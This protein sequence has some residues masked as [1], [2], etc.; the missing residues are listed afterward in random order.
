[1]STSLNPTA[2][3][4]VLV[5][6]EHADGVV[7]KVSLELLAGA[8]RLGSPIAVVIG[9]DAQ[10]HVATL[11]AHGADTV[12]VATTDVLAQHPVAPAVDLLAHLAATQSP[13]AVLVPSSRDGKEIAARLA[14]RIG[15]GLITDAVDV[16]SADGGV[17]A[18]QSIFGGSTVVTSTVARGIPVVTVRPNSI[19]IDATPGAGSVLDLSDAVA[20]IGESARR[21][22]I[23]Q[24]VA[25]ERSTR[26]AL[27][28][29]SI[30]VTGGRGVG[31]ADGFGI[32]E[33]LA[34]VLGAAVGASRAATD[35]GWYPHSYQVGQ[36]GTTVSP[37][38]YIANGVSGA[39]QHRAGMQ[40]SKTIVVVNKDPEAPLFE[41]ADFGVVGDLFTVVPSLTQ[42]L[43]EQKS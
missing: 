38:V 15:S 11:A 5:L 18:T 7:A 10:S 35:A 6:V 19:A 32:I 28:E 14:V 12:A 3:G 23:T 39:I 42:A 36:T 41:I 9:P 27:A 2:G 25:Q 30:V 1:M 17:Q 4:P 34:D 31:S 37:Q 8:R 24:R 43:R 33:D 40:T 29:A 26:P 16:V 13:Q 21:A 22:R 20:A